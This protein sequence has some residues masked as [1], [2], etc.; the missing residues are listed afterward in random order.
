MTL[1]QYDLVSSDAQI[2]LQDFKMEVLGALTQDYAPV[3]EALG[4]SQ[5]D[6]ALKSTYEVN[7]SAAGLVE[8]DGDPR[9]RKLGEKGVS[10]TPR[11]FTDGIKELASKIEAPEWRRRGWAD[12]PAVMAAVIKLF[13]ERLIAEVIEANGTCYDGVAFFHATHPVNVFDSSKGTFSNTTGSSALSLSTLKA[14]KIAMRKM[15]AANGEPLGVEPRYLIVPP[16]LAETAKDLLENDMIIDSPDGG[17]TFGAQTN[18]HRGTLKIIVSNHLTVETT[19]YLLGEKL[20]MKP[21]VYTTREA[22][23]FI[24]Q[25]K[26]SDLYANTYHVALQVKLEAEAALL[27]P[28]CLHRFQA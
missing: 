1:K 8:F 7:L 26:S 2:A 21:W 11:T 3:L 4:I 23:E 19:W 14:A 5:T 27:M 9:F 10:L 6:P 24:V 15:K 18:R 13:P 16:A 20:G 12:E 25:D 22:P 17:T 28:H